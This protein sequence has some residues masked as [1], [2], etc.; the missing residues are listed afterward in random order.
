MRLSVVVA[1]TVAAG[2]AHAES[3]GD[4]LRDSDRARGG[5][6]TG[7]TWTVEVETTEDGASSKRSYIV[8]GRGVDAHVET[9]AP[10]RSKGEIMLFN[11]RSLWYFKPG[12]RKPVSISSR[13]KLTGQAANGD[14]ASTNYAR[15][16]E[17]SIVGMEQVGGEESFK[18]ELKARAKNVTYDR[19]LYWVSKARRVGIKA[20]FLTLQGDV[21]KSATFVYGNKLSMAGKTYDFVSQMVISDPSFPGNSTSIVYG[22]PMAS[23]HPPALFNINNIVR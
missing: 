20:D 19:I 16:Y 7:I 1:L 4:L 6:D 8:K 13:Q 17:G 22:T 11:D 21:F 3:A 15:D 5:L 18:L 12:L 2:Y 10:A 23:E 9:T 14:I